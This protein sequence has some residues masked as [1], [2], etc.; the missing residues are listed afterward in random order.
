MATA[1]HRKKEEPLA[2]YRR[3]PKPETGKKDE[4]IYWYS[5][6]FAGKRI[7]ESANTT[8][9]TIAEE[10]MKNRRL[11]LERALAGLPVEDK[12]R[13]ILSVKDVTVPY[14]E[15]YKVNHS[16]SA[17]AFCGPCIANVN[18]LLGGVLLPDLTEERI[19]KYMEARL[20]EEAAGRTINA[21][22]GE[23]SRAIG[24]PWRMLWP[25]V[26]RLEERHDVGVALTPEQ[27]HRLVEAAER[28]A[29]GQTYQNVK[30]RNGNT[31]RQRLGPKGVMMPTLIRLALL[32]G[33]RA[34][35]LT[36]LRWRQI[37]FRERTITVGK[38]KTRAGSGRI[39]P[40]GIE[41]WLTVEAHLSWWAHRFGEAHPDLCVFPWG[42]PQPS[43]P[44]RP[45][46]TLKHA[47]ESVRV[48]AGIACRWHDLRH[49]F[50]TRLAEKGVPESTMLALMG[51]MSRAM[52]E[53]Y[54]H[55]R[56]AAKRE[57]VQGLSVGKPVKSSGVATISTTAIEKAT[58]RR[59]VTH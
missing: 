29:A 34:E 35:E 37:D 24:H 46:T 28:L 9:K 45:I 8:R 23:L 38:A 57:A 49:S 3:G 41:A 42:S 1:A 56:M 31:H 39:V 21:E 52:L 17:T 10:A 47:W 50:C 40:L 55:I 19:V 20:G 12:G 26:K 54:S 36:S 14:L 15:Q 53:R 43:D 4:R 33:L 30:R 6:T 25:R 22:L 44:T 48:E 16:E 58:L 2:L 7:Q 59:P 51:H 13:R 5:F 27:E 32:T 18:R 11:G